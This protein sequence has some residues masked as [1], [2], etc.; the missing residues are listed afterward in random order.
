MARTFSDSWEKLG[1]ILLKQESYPDDKN[2]FSLQIQSLLEL[3][4][5][6]DRYLKLKN[7]LQRDLR[8]EPR[9]RQDA[10]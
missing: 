9:R 6:K 8:F 2:D 4:L 7:L 5:S 10:G 1:G 3:D